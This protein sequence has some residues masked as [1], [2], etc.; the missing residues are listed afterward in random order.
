M[1]NSSKSIKRSKEAIERLNVLEG[2]LSIAIEKCKELNKTT[3]L[4]LQEM[5]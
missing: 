3:K 1:M 2:K 5:K 4:C